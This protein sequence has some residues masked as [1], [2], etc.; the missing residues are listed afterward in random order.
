MSDTPFRLIA[1]TGCLALACACGRTLTV[2]D[3]PELKLR[4][5]ASVSS[6]ADPELAGVSFGV[7]NTYVILASA[8]VAEEPEFMREQLFTYYTDAAEWQASSA[9]GP[10]LAGSYTHTPRYWPFGDVKMDFLALAL[11]PAAYDALTAAPGSIS[12]Y[13]PSDGGAAG[14]VSIMD[15]NTY[16]NQYDVMYAASN[17]LSVTGNSGGTVPLRFRHTMAVVGFTARSASDADIFTLKD[18]KFKDLQYRGSLVIDNTTTVPGLNWDVPAG[19][20][21]QA[22]KSVPLIAPD[23]SV[24]A[25]AA[26]CTDHLLVIPQAARTVE[27]TYHVKNSILD[28]DVT[29][30]LPLPRITWKAGCRYIYNLI[31]DLTGV[32]GLSLSVPDD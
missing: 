24:P 8:S 17:D 13:R 9:S 2:M 18:I 22:D 31:F 1:L 30:I 29:R 20:A 6:K 26:K 3:A 15:W 23:F 19:D 10:G 16:D 4:A 27:M 14:G 11:Q 12:F 32:Q 25:S 5:V 28:Q 7:D 21:Y